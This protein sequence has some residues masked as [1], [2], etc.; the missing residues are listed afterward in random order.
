MSTETLIVTAIIA[1]LLTGSFISLRS[2]TNSEKRPKSHLQIRKIDV[3]FKSQSNMFPAHWWQE[4]INAYVSDLDED[5][6]ERTTFILE[7]ALN[8]YPQTLRL[9]IDEIFVFK[10]LNLY[11]APFGGTYIAP[12][13]NKI[14]SGPQKLDSSKW[15]G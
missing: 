1:L 13:K 5:E 12:V 7:K 2:A 3:Y 6:K 8:K 14:R 4:P 15:K 9:P 10:S 11:N